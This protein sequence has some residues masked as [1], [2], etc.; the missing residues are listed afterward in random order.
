MFLQH[1]NIA[2]VHKATNTQN[3]GTEYTVCNAPYRERFKVPTTNTWMVTP[4][5]ICMRQWKHVE[6]EFRGKARQG[7]VEH[8]E[9]D[10]RGKARQGKAKWNMLKLMLEL[11]GVMSVGK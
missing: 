8:V 3:N 9:V 2:S 10:V 6:V 5:P 11:R 1:N 4:I 7:K